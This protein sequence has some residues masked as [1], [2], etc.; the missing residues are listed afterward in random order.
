MTGLPL[1]PP[2]RFGS[3]LLIGSIGSC[4]PVPHSVSRSRTIPEEDGARSLIISPQGLRST[5]HDMTRYRCVALSTH[6][7]LRYRAAVVDDFGYPIRRVIAHETYPCRHCL[8][9]ASADN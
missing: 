9:E 3:R 4:D 1:L 6:D 7:A 8:R 2:A 5:D